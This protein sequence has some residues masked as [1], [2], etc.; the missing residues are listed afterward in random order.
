VTSEL[1]DRYRERRRAAAPLRTPLPDVLVGD[2]GTTYERWRPGDEAVLDAL[3]TASVEHLVEFM[4]FAA[5]EPMPL[6]ER[7][8]LLAAWDAEWRRHALA[9]FKVPDDEGAPCGMATINRVPA[10]HEVHLGYWLAPWAVGRGRMTAAARCLATEA[11]RHDEVETVVVT[12]DLANV[13]SAGVP[14]RLGF[15]RTAAYSRDPLDGGRSGVTV[16]WEAGRAWSSM[17]A[18]VTRSA[19]PASVVRAP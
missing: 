12:H 10:A 16:R 9:P 8:A 15:L 18:G 19:G 1:E 5:E 7:R 2:D 6:D 3:V 13:R 14:R 11:F 4:A 17:D